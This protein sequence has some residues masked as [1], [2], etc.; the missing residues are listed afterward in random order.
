MEA[1]QAATGVN[2]E[3]EGMAK[4]RLR[5]P[6][7]M[8]G[9]GIKR[10]TDS[11]YPTF[12]GALLDIL[13][14]CVDRKDRNGEVRKGTYSD[15]LAEV[16]GEGAFDE[17]GHMNFKFLGSTTVG[18]YPGEMQAA[19]D[20]LRN[21]AATNYGM[22][23]VGE[24]KKRGIEWGPRWS[25]RQLEC[26]TGA[27]QKGGQRGEWKPSLPT[28]ARRQLTEQGRKK[29]AAKRETRGEERRKKNQHRRT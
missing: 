23:R 9:G 5:L 22:L 27:L 6:A 8:K 29:G 7:R 20:V 13:P 26:A 4:E 17:E 18:P 14:R 24:T 28:I 1:V 15:Q 25:K 10:S 21:E 19:W 12:L 2:F 16:V 11:R 3:T